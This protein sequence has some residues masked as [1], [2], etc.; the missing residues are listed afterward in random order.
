MTEWTLSSLH[1]KKYGD[2]AGN[3][4]GTPADPS[5][6]CE[7]AG[8][9]GRGEIPHQCS[10]KRGYGPEKAYCKQHDPASVK[11]RRD[12]EAA[13]YEKHM[14]GRR[15]EWAGPRLFAALCK[16]ADGDN[17][18]RETAAEAIKDMRKRDSVS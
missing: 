4:R 13:R 18:P 1:S 9:Y 5:R 15:L 8:G 3:P 11:A 14:A 2:W 7:R 12:A 6:C 16:I 17:N 10:K